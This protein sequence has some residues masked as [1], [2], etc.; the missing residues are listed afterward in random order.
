[1]LFCKWWLYN[2]TKHTAE[3]GSNEHVESV[4]SRCH[5]EGW[6]YTLSEIVKFAF[7][8]SNPC[9][10]V[11][12]IANPTVTLRAC[13]AS[14]RFPDTILWCAQV[15][16]APDV[17]KIKVFKRMELPTHSRLQSLVVAILNQFLGLGPMLTRRTPMKNA[18]KNM[19]SDTINK[20]IPNRLPNWTK[21]VCCPSKVPSRTISRHHT[22]MVLLNNLNPL[23]LTLPPP[24]YPWKYITD[25]DVLIKAPVEAVNGHRLG[26]TKW[27]G[28]FLIHVFSFSFSLP[29]SLK[30]IESSSQPWKG[31]VL[32]TELQGLFFI[33]FL[34]TFHTLSPH[35]SFLHSFFSLSFLVFLSLILCFSFLLFLP[36][37][38]SYSRILPSSL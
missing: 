30:E 14:S 12:A 7:T 36:H 24:T 22:Y 5:I 19:T 23:L 11:N 21:V 8:Y 28:C 10:A 18:K 17:N 15:A 38:T 27:N 32:T 3:A 37:A 33:F 2:R 35:E 6:S 25:P 13:A 29:F 1:M 16:E 9:K 26:S 20:I 4:E 34:F 31:C